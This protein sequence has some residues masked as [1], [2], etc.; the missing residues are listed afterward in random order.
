M[1]LFADTSVWSLTL[2]RDDP[3]SE[4]PVVALIAALEG[5][6]A[7]FTTGLVLQE[8]LQGFVRPRARDQVIDKLS[9]LPL[10][11]PELEDHI[12]AAELRNRCRRAGVQVDTVDVLLA[13]LCIRY[14]L[15]LLTVDRDF[16]HIARHEPLR[17]WKAR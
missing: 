12:E 7:V 8:L 4:P 11:V 16:T 2:R 10:L 15:T 5:S 13:H 14:D 17:L 6:Q 9:A 1:N 3:Q